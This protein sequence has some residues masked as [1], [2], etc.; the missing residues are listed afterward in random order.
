LLAGGTSG[1]GQSADPVPWFWT[2]DGWSLNGSTTGVYGLGRHPSYHVLRSAGNFESQSEFVQIAMDA[3]K[4]I[5]LE[6]LRIIRGEPLLYQVTVDNEL[7]LTVKTSQADEDNVVLD[8][9][10][11]VC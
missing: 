3:A 7:K 1:K 9:S 4:K 6:P 5:L 11:L 8:Q 10:C 2:L